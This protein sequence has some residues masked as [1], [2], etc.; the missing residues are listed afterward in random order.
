[1]CD[2]PADMALKRK[3]IDM[4]GKLCRGEMS[5]GDRRESKSGENTEGDNVYNLKRWLV[6][7]YRSVVQRHVVDVKV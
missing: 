7:K 6:D 1:M 4:G 2:A 3:D 5:Y